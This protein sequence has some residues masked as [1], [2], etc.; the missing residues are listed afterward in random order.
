M[1]NKENKEVL[2]NKEEVIDYTKLP[3]GHDVLKPM[4][5][6]LPNEQAKDGLLAGFSMFMSIM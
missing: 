1:E 4:L 2:E 3:A 5:D 6:F